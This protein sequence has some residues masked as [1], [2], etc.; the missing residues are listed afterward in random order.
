[1]P[2]SS[3]NRP[4]KYPTCPV[5]DSPLCTWPFNTKE[6]NFY[7]LFCTKQYSLVTIW[8]LDISVW[9]TKYMYWSGSTRLDHFIQ[10]GHT[11]YFLLNEKVLSSFQIC[12]SVRFFLKL[13]LRK[14][15]LSGVRYSNSHCIVNIAIGMTWFLMGRLSVK[16]RV[17]NWL[18]IRNLDAAKLDCVIINKTGMDRFQDWCKA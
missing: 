17:W 9:T 13:T 4:F 1:M 18:A 10:K 5:F 7:D 3:W 6:N 15:D 16:K 11:K 2:C 12:S 14:L 8:K